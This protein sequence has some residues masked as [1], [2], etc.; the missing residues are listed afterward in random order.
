MAGY[1]STSFQFPKEKDFL[2]RWACCFVRAAS[3][4][5][6][7]QIFYCPHPRHLSV[8]FPST[9]E[10]CW[11]AV[12]CLNEQRIVPKRLCSHCSYILLVLFNPKLN[13][14]KKKRS[15]IKKK[16]S[17]KILCNNKRIM[18]VFW[19]YCGTSVMALCFVCFLTSSRSLSS[20]LISLPPSD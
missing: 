7:E 15:W 20:V 5:W 2:A 13:N 8:L 14:N 17:F 18:N 10:L 11:K 1:F 16:K 9:L 3:A 19:S 12:M 4:V 6:V